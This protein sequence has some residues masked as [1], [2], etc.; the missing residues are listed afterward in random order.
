LHHSDRGGTYASEDSQKILAVLN[1]TCSMSRRGDCCDNAVLESFFST[2]KSE[3]ADRFGSE[4]KMERFDYLERTA[5]NGAPSLEAR[6]DQF[7]RALN[8][9]V[10]Y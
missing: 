5:T 10:P 7:F 3:L 9:R 8:E 1:I 2:V 6:A 4:A